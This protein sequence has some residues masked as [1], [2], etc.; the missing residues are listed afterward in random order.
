[1]TT[2]PE[3]AERRGINRNAA[4]TRAILEAINAPG[5][6][7]YKVVF[8][9]RRTSYVSV[10]TPCPEE[11]MILAQAEQILNNKGHR[12]ITSCRRI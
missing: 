11:A 1:M 3:Y 6:Y 7:R 2:R 5:R 8:D 12:N 4:A 10:T 9:T